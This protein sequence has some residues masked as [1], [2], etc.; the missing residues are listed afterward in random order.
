V[1]ENLRR[2]VRSALAGT[3]K[4]NNTM[5]LIGCSLED[6]KRH[7]ESQFISG[8]TWDNYGEWHIDHKIPCSSFNLAIAENQHECFNY[9]NL[10]PLWAKDNLSKGNKHE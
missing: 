3:N 10:Q 6:L 2:R 9:K 8:M 7:I 5:S 4:S 1:R